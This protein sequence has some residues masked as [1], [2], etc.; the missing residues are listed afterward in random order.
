MQ[1]LLHVYK[2]HLAAFSTCTLECMYDARASAA[3]LR[4]STQYTQPTTAQLKF[5]SIGS[6]TRCGHGH[7]TFECVILF[8]LEMFCLCFLCYCENSSSCVTV[9]ILLKG[10]GC[11]RLAAGITLCVVHACVPVCV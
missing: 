6:L 4:P 9:K 11:R 8:H 2:L 3:L 5:L 10:E 7:S 1:S